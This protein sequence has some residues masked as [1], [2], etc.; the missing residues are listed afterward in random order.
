MLGSSGNGRDVLLL[1]YAR[2]DDLPAR[3]GR[4]VERAGKGR[5]LALV[6][7][8]VLLEAEALAVGEEH[9]FREQQRR[10]RHHRRVL[11][12]VHLR[13]DDIEHLGILDEA[14]AQRLEDVVHHHGG[15]L[16]LGHGVARGVHLVAGQV[17]L[18]AGRVVRDV[19]GSLVVPLLQVGVLVL[20]GVGQFVRHH[21]LLLFGIDPVEQVHGLGFGVVV[22]FDLLLEERQQ[23]GLELEVVVEEAEFLEHDFVALQALGALVLVE[24]FFEVAFHGGARGELALDGA[25]DGQAG[26]VGGEFDELVDQGEELFGL[27]GRD[28]GWRICRL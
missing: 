27:L 7:P 22:G 13:L 1:V 28:A 12:G 4:A 8:D 10:A 16:A 11:G 23:E 3:G 20:Q 2:I 21:R 17:I 25:F 24:F 15:R 9:R 14:L 19:V 18:I 5:G 6:H 26:F